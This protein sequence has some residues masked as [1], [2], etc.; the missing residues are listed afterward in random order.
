MKQNNPDNIDAPLNKED[1][2]P[3]PDDQDFDF[4]SIYTDNLPKILKGLNISLAVTSYQAQRLFFIRTDG[5]TIDNNFKHFPRPMGIYADR[6]RLTLGTLTQVLEFKRNDAILKK[7]KSGEL[8][9]T[10]RMAKKVLEKDPEKKRLLLEKRKAE[11]AK[12]KKSDALYLSRAAATTGMINIHDIA[13]GDEGLWVVN[14]TFSCLATLSPN[15]SFVARWKP[16]FITELAPEDRCHLNGVAMLNGRPKYVTT[17]NKFDSQDSWVNQDK[18]DGT[19]LD[20]DRNE[21]L[22]DGMIM[23]H[24]PRCHRGMVYICDSGRGTVLQFNP[25][26]GNVS[27]IIKLPGFPRG[28]NFWGPLMFVGLSKTR[29]SETR[30]PL[31]VN[32]E[33][34]ETSCG[35][36]IFNLEDHAEVAHIRF[37]G[38]L[39]QIYDIAVIPEA[40]HPELLH[41]GDT[42]IRHTFDFQ[43]AL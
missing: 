21:I 42:L 4:S 25:L 18:H 33:Y 10:D 13:W 36:W 16:P 11:L 9:N 43:E 20:V 31:P 7:I 1:E 41:T 22:F 30:Q 15:H 38:D 39:E 17:F 3:Q 14:S 19:L 32:E 12:V 37:A 40:I 6:A 8:D 35:V 28:M 26:T 23:P 34:A 5:Q 24:S 27:E 29:P 2:A